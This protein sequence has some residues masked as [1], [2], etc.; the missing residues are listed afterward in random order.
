MTFT[1]R[2]IQSTPCDV[3][4]T[5]FYAKKIDSLSLRLVIFN[6]SQRILMCDVLNNASPLTQLRK[7]VRDSPHFLARYPFFLPEFAIFSSNSFWL[8]T[9]LTSP[10]FLE[11]CIWYIGFIITRLYIFVNTFFQNC[12]KMLHLIHQR[13][14]I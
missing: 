9:F 1:V 11:W 4:N 13:C 8:V 12:K 2:P 7:P 14:I 5:S 3:S 10:Y 6:S